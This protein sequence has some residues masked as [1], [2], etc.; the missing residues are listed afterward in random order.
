MIITYLLPGGY[1]FI[2]S[3]AVYKGK[4]TPKSVNHVNK[5]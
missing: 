1:I 4:F 5:F 2:R 3:E